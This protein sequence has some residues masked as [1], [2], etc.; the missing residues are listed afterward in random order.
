MSE[1]REMAAAEA[2]IDAMASAMANAVN[3]ADSFEA[4]AAEFGI[5]IPPEASP[6]EQWEYFELVKALVA[7]ERCMLTVVKRW[8]S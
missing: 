6:E 3:E 4:V 2:T 7:V 1:H 5:V 8:L